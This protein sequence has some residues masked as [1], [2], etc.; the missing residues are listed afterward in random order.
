MLFST[1]DSCG[2]QRNNIFD[3][4]LRK[5]LG[6]LLEFPDIEFVFKAQKIISQEKNIDL[7]ITIAYP[8]PINWGAALSKSIS[9]INSFPKE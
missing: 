9:K 3:K 1:A 7:L 6:R 5:T 8:H 4:V 2:N